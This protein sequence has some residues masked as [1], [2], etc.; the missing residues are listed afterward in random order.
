MV[1][2]LGKLESNL[3]D[4]IDRVPHQLQEALQNLLE[5]DARRRPNAQNFSMVGC[6]FHLTYASFRIV[7][8]LVDLLNS[9]NSWSRR[10]P[11]A[12]TPGLFRC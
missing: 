9:N 5:V 7:F 12:L 4:I 8:R 10:R 2:F 3:N 11:Q 1:I 6:A